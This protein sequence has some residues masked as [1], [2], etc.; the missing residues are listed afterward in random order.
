MRIAVSACLLGENCK[1]SGGNNAHAGV[2]AFAQGKTV[3]PVCPEVM[4][5]LPVPRKPAEIVDGCVRCEDGEDV[6][7]AFRRGAAL[8]LAAIERAN[9]ELVILQPR[10]PSCGLSQVYDGSFSGRLVTGRGVFAQMLL[11]AGFS[12]MEADAYPFPQGK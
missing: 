6:D 1:Y 3:I 5:G 10:S 4:G 2:M 8:A 11:D 9:A 7:A 12:V